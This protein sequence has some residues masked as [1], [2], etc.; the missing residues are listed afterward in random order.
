VPV[1][2]A[3]AIGVVAL[4]FSAALYIHQ[5]HTWSK[6]FMGLRT[7]SGFGYNSPLLRARQHPSW[8]NPAAVLTA[9][10]RIAVAVWIV[11]YRNP[12]FA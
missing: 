6:V 12:R 4:A 3:V 5:R 1:R 11:A 2:I 10:G 8:E 9:L 7:R